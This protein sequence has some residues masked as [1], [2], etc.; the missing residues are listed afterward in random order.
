MV[1]DGN[2]YKEVMMDSTTCT[3]GMCRWGSMERESKMA[4]GWCWNNVGAGAAKVISYNSEN[5]SEQ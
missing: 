5:K 4:A 2:C 3:R 1:V